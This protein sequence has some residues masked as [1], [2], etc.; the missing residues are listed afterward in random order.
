MSTMIEAIRPGFKLCPV[1][2]SVKCKCEYEF[3]K[4]SK[5]WNPANDKILGI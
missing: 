4:T 3:K 5:S 2:D 1:C